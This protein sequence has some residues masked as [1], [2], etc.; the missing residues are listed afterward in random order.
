MDISIK[1]K[2]ADRARELKARNPFMTAED[3]AELAGIPL[4]QV[5]NALARRP[6]SDKRKSRAR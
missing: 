5:K 4:P 6:K 1:P 2:S 3:I